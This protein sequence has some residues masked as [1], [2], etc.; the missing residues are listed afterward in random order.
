MARG[1]GGALPHDI[2]PHHAQGTSRSK[3]QKVGLA[4][5]GEGRNTRPHFIS[6]ICPGMKTLTLK[7][8]GQRRARPAFSSRRPRSRAG[9]NSMNRDALCCSITCKPPPGASIFSC[10]CWTCRTPQTPP[11]P[12]PVIQGSR[13]PQ[14]GRSRLP[15]LLQSRRCYLGP[16]RLPAWS[17]ESLRIISPALWEQIYLTRGIVQQM[18]LPVELI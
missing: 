4:R 2:Y 7:L 9:G 5:C 18:R 15:W 16:A 14:S 17:T 3:C 1:G 8:H 13:G 6:V 12:S 10:P 11:R